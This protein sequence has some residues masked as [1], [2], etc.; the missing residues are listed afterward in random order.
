[1]NM[2]MLWYDDDKQT[3]LDQK[4]ARAVDYYTSKY[5]AR[6]NVC[7]VNPSMLQGSSAIAAGVRVMAARMVMTNHFWLGVAE[8]A[9]PAEAPRGNRG[10]GR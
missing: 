7:H 5:G 2:G 3:T 9:G 6:P 8:S 4:V 1:M 10:H